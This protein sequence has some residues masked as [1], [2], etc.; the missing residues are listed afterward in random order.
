MHRSFTIK[1][2]SGAVSAILLF[3]LIYQIPTVQAHLAWRIDFATTYVRGV[4]YPAGPMPTPRAFATLTPAPTQTAALTQPITTQQARPSPTLPPTVTPA[5]PPAEVILTP[6]KWEKQ[7]INSC[8]PTTLSM[9]LHF[10]GWEGDQTTIEK[11]VK[12]KPED[13]N[14]NVEELAYFAHTQAGWLRMEYRVGMTLDTLKRFMAAGIPV[15]I[16]ETFKM[17]EGYWPND[18]RW[19]GHYLLITG[20]NDAQGIFI[21]QDSFA[22]ADHPVAYQEVDDNWKAFNRVLLLLYP[23]EQEETVKS[24]LGSDWDLDTNRA[25][26]L[27][28]AQAEAAANPQ[29][30][31][32]WFNVG[33]NQVYFEHYTEAAVAYDTARTIGLPQRMLR[34]QFGPFLAYFHSGRTDDLMALVDYALQRTA[35]SEEAL[36]WQGWGR[37]RQGDKA[38]AEADFK[39]ALEANYTYQDAKYALDYLLKN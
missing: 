33:T 39:K 2:L 20:Y 27:K 16:E 18:D 4:L 13:R 10:Y 26:A 11:L 38:G 17:A 30:A 36:L 19:A 23:P 25:N 31:F 28:T 37:Y 32:A 34:Y 24:I 29:D 21:T 14:V 6:P 8:G 1:F 15:M 35:N 9:Y 3:F 12:P 5:P 22:G 7:G